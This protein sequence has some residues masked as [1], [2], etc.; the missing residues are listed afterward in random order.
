MCGIVGFANKETLENKNVNIKA[1]MDRI[2]HRGPNS[3]GQY[4]DENIAL[5]FRRLSIID[6][7]SGNQP[8]YSPDGNVVIIFNGEIYNFLE[9]RK[10]LEELGHTFLTNSDT[11]VLLHTYL[12][13][14]EDSVNHLR[15][16]FA[17][18]VWD[19]CEE[20]L[21]LARDYFG[22]KPL[23]YGK[24]GETFMFASEIKAFLDNDKFVKELNKEALKPYLIFQYSV[25]NETFF[26]GIFK[27]DPGHTLVYQN[28]NIEIKQYHKF[29]FEQ[30]NKFT[31]EEWLD[32][33]EDTMRESVDS[34]R[35]SDVKVGGFL[36]GGVDSS[37]ITNILKPAN[38]FSVG[39]EETGF[40]EV[41][42]AKALSDI[43]GIENKC[44]MI[45]PDE[46]MDALPAVQYYSDEPHANLS[47]VALFFL[48]ELAAKDVTVVLSGEGADEMFA[49]YDLYVDSDFTKEYRKLPLGFRRT[50]KKVASKMP[51][52]KGKQ[53]FI[54]N[55][56]RV[57][58]TF[59]GQAKIFNE[60][61]VDTYIREDYKKTPSIAEIVG[62]HYAHAQNYDEVTKKQYLD[63]HLWQPYDILLKADKMT[64]AHSLELRVPFLDKKVWELAKRVPS[65]YKVRKGVGKYILR[66]SALKML[67]EEWAK[68]K[69][70]GF[71]VPFIH[72]I[73][74]E[75]YCEKVRK[76]FNEPFVKDFFDVQ[77][78][79]IMLDEHCD[80]KKNN[81]RKIYT[82]M[83]FL[84]WYDVYF[85]RNGEIKK[86]CY[87]L[88]IVG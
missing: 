55:G 64:M 82:I 67:P 83:S 16:M 88:Y 48:S 14:G 63:F 41:T 34:H 38:T 6:L 8:M 81:G 47:A 32:A 79:N 24:F 72:W 30:N 59:I 13:Y 62:P 25:L 73:K 84:I 9:L 3:S 43:L 29:I 23:Y 33:L 22:I 28:G 45:E 1:M 70:K 80:G 85:V 20:K 39:F 68:R 87:D 37:Y 18:A 27:L 12:Q 65:E 58:E 71:M 76:V 44:K 4:V 35:I 54:R 57:E 60:N 77:K 61:E 10:N 56:G 42:D 52:I 15:G 66:A 46:Y 19:K 31:E 7:V 75:E 78:L 40:N 86:S 36:S 11:E 50:M 5:G 49:G 74:K 69:K 53:F 26:K 2:I 51:N 21:F 17:F